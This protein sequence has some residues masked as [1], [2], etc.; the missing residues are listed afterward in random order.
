M[1]NKQNKVASMRGNRT[2]NLLALIPTPD[3]KHRVKCSDVTWWI[4]FSHIFSR[5]YDGLKS[6]H[7]L[8]CGFQSGCLETWLHWNSR[9]SMD[10]LNAD[11]IT[12]AISMFVK[13]KIDKFN[14]VF[15][16]HKLL[17]INKLKAKETYIKRSSFQC[18]SYL[19]VNGSRCEGTPLLHCRISIEEAASW[20]DAH[21]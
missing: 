14:E 21:A 15:F 1:R 2:V 19:R 12:W 20:V 9:I 8:T 11:V 10:D 4:Y 16:V 18:A 7:A 6:F 17:N 5:M 3:C 13:L